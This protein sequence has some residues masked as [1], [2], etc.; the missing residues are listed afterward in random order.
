MLVNEIPEA[1]S[2]ALPRRYELRRVVGCGGTATVYSHHLI[3]T[4]SEKPA[5]PGYEDQDDK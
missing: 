3:R 4:G 1:L 2:W 5:L